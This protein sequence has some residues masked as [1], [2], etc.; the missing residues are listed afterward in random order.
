[1]IIGVGDE[2]YHIPEEYLEEVRNLGIKV[3]VCPTFEAV[4]TYN[5]T[6]ENGLDT[7]A[8]LLIGNK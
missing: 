2:G 5:F 7:V 4:S 6:I 8:F 1:M 3:D